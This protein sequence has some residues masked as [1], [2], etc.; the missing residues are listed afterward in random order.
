MFPFGCQ[1]NHRTNNTTLYSALTKKQN[2]LFKKVAFA[3]C[4]SYI[5]QRGKNSEN[6]FIKEELWIY[7]LD[8]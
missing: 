1:N 4:S 2:L 6:L 8:F 3:V 7:V 5:P